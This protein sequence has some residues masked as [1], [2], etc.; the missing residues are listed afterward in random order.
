LANA[1]LQLVGFAVQPL[2]KWIVISANFTFVSSILTIS[3]VVLL[4]GL[5]KALAR[6]RESEER[7]R[8]L[9]EW[10]P[11]PLAVHDG[12]RFVYVNPAAI[13][14]FGAKSA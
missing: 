12:Q 7:Y 6:K 4:S 5:E 1:D 3:I 8:T 2:V 10:T 14:L 11:E 13:K 9:I